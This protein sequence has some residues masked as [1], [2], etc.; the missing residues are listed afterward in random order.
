MHNRCPD[1][2]ITVPYAQLLIVTARR[3]R[4]PFS[5]FAEMRTMVRIRD[6]NS[7]VKQYL[8]ETERMP[9]SP[10]FNRCYDENII[11]PYAQ[12]GG[13]V[14]T[15]CEKAW[16]LA[17]RDRFARNR[18]HNRTRCHT[19][20]SNKYPYNGGEEEELSSFHNPSS[21]HPHYYSTP[22]VYTGVNTY[23]V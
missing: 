11:V 22:I 19:G 20:S 7:T 4:A 8:H 3:S 21:G 13:G 16:Y 14:R 23:G 1:E 12:C 10:I 15:S 9:S 5:P 6:V 2:N 17:M 18:S